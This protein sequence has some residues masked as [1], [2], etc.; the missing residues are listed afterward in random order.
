VIQFKINLEGETK[1]K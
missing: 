1:P